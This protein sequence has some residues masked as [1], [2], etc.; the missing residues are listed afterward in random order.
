MNK[1]TF[2]GI[3]YFLTIAQMGSIRLAS[4]ELGVEQKTI[5]HKIKMLEQHLGITLIESSSKGSSLTDK[6][7]EVHGALAQ[8]FQGLTNK[9][10]VISKGKN[11][12]QRTEKF[13]ILLPPFTANF[14][15][16]YIIPELYRKFPEIHVE[17]ISFNLKHMLFYGSQLKNIINNMDM[18]CLDN[19]AL[20]IIH[21]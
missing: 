9:V 2:E 6:G 14:F 3:Q 18:L 17:L 15:S 12:T 10:S 7:W 1:Y 11:S 13:R 21:P 19:R 5:R 8:D 4:N 16:L 20:S